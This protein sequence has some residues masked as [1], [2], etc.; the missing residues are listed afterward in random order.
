DVAELR[1]PNLLA[2]VR[3]DGDSLP[4]EGVEEDFA[5]IVNRAAVDRIAAGD[6]LARGERLGL[7][8]P[9]GRRAGLGEVKRV[10]IVR[11]RRDQLHRAVDDE[12]RRFVAVT[13]RGREGEAQREL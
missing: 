11:E 4:V 6:A 1:S 13:G 12:R 10:E 9:L 2:A 3:V 7:E 8:H 5:R